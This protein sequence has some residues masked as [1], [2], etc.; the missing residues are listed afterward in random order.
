MSS[1]CS[2]ASVFKD[3]HP[4]HHRH[5]PCTTV[6]R[7]NLSHT[8][9]SPHSPPLGGQGKWLVRSYPTLFDGFVKQLH[10]I[11]SLHAACFKSL[12]P[13]DQDGLYRRAQRG[14]K[15]ARRPPQPPGP[16]RVCS[17]TVTKP[18]PREGRHITSG[19]RPRLL[20][21]AYLSTQWSSLAAATGKKTLQLTLKHCQWLASGWCHTA[22]RSNWCQLHSLTSFTKRNAV[23][24]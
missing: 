22:C 14:Q 13:G 6:P 18:R 4:P 7:K 2:P 10:H 16:W 20:S 17:R 15:R 23:I 5:G 19:N 8:A 1:H 12:C 21:P 9:F 11:S 3:P 24:T